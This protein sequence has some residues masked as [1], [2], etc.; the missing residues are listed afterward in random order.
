MGIEPTSKAW[1]AFILPMNYARRD[2]PFYFIIFRN[3]VKYNFI[4]IFFKNLTILQKDSFPSWEL[5]L[6]RRA[7]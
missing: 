7:Y 6:V 2:L 4:S 3:F 1:E 5:H